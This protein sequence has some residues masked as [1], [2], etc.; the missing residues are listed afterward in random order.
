[1]H[2]PLR[3]TRMKLELEMLQEY[4]TNQRTYKFL[5]IQRQLGFVYML[6]MAVYGQQNEEV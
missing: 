6:I 1:M 5:D 3:L 4:Q 2:N